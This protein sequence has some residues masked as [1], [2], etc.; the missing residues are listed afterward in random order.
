MEHRN[1]SSSDEDINRLEKETNA[2]AEALT[3][4]EIVGEKSRENAM[5]FGELSAEELMHEKK[6]RRKIDSVIMPMV[7][8]V[9]LMNYIDRN[10]LV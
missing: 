5:H 7:V 4:N 2:H 6:L 10:K 9:Y 3:D 8:L 1:Q